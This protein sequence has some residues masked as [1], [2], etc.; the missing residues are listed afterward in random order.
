[1][2]DN[3]PYYVDDPWE[4][5]D[6]AWT[7]ADDFNDPKLMEIAFKVC[8]RTAQRFRTN[9]ERNKWYKVDK[10]MKKAQIPME[11]WKHCVGWA[12]TKNKQRIIIK[13]TAL[14]SYMLNAAAMQDWLVDNPNVGNEMIDTLGFHEGDIS[15]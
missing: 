9:A 3:D 4:D 15:D 2:S 1:M 7:R 11:W 8:G 10:R 5:E 13:L 14:A 6:T 12:R